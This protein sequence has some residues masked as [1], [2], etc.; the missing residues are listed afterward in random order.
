MTA[1]LEVQPEL[2]RCVALYGLQSRKDIE[3]TKLSDDTEVVEEALFGMEDPRP[4]LLPQ[5][6]GLEP[7]PL[8]LQANQ[9]LTQVKG[10]FFGNFRV[11]PPVILLLQGARMTGARPTCSIPGI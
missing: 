5:P 4:P 11:I 7:G 2:T 6:P 10:V 9:N 3:G 8:G 1:L